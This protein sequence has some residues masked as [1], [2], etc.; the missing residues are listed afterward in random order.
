M[1]EKKIILIKKT[2]VCSSYDD[3]AMGY[4]IKRGGSC[5]SFDDSG[6]IYKRVFQVTYINESCCTCTAVAFHVR[7]SHVTQRE[8][9]CHSFD[10]SGHTYE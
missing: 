8:G 1:F 2:I 9:L 7:M 6:H 3:D 5:H 4:V 10:D